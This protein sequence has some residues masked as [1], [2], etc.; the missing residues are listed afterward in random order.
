MSDDMTIGGIQAPSIQ[1]EVDPDGT[2]YV[3]LRGAWDIRS[4]RTRVG[5]LRQ[6]LVAYSV[7]PARWDLTGIDDLDPAGAAL[8]WQA[9]DRKRPAAL[10]VRP[11]HECLVDAMKALSGAELVRPARDLA[12]PLVHL[13]RTALGLADH[14]AAMLTLLGAAALDA[15]RLLRTPGALPWRAISA[16]IYRTGAQAMP[17]TALVGMLIGI[18]LSYLSGEQLRNFGADVY[19]VNIMGIGILRELG[20]LLAAIL[21]AGRSGSSMTAQIGAMRVTQE[22]DAM[23]VMGLPHTVWLVLPKMIGQFVALPLIVVWTDLLALIGGMLGAHWQLGI[24]YDQFL[25]RLPQVV[26][27]ANLWLGVGK[28]AVFGA[29]IALVACHFGLRIQPDTDSLRRG[30]TQAVV[31]AIT[32]VLLAD[33]AFAVLFSGVGM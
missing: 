14:V 30:T 26:P 7:G 6:Q 27:L 1:A 17:I 20:P 31:T 13:G 32:V 12:W 33:A 21:N 16:N 28:G 10:T 9:W 8:L 25:L 19:I 24:G 3:K 2:G 11:E 22:L 15:L 18:V 29:L 4:I 5:V 23:T